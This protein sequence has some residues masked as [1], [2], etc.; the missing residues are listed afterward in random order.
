M[1]PSILSPVPCFVM[2]VLGIL[3]LSISSDAAFGE[4]AAIQPLF[5]AATELPSTPN[6]ASAVIWTGSSSTAGKV[7]PEVL[8]D[9]VDGRTSSFLVVLNA[10]ADLRKAQNIRDHDARGWYVY[11]TLSEHASRSQATLKAMLDSQGVQYRS[12][13]VVN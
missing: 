11:S 5:T 9:T 10:Q 12:F 2:L 3:T 8:D 6:P 7:A 1:R 4:T 13:W